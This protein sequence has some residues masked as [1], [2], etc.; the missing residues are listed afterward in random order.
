[1]WLRMSVKSVHLQ[2]DFFESHSSPQRALRL[3]VA[4]VLAEEWEFHSCA[5]LSILIGS[6]VPLA[7]GAEQL[8]T[9]A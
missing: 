3:G 4:V 1:M 7:T 9:G 2:R 5:R 8:A 6:A